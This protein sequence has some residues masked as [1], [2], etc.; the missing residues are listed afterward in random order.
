M[1]VFSTPL[2][3]GA[4]TQFFHWATAVLVLAAFVT[5]LG[6]SEQHVYSSALDSA[7]RIHETLGAAVFSLVL[8]RV[9]WRLFDATHVDSPMKPWM[10]QV[11]SVMHAMLYML[12]IA[13]PATG[14]MS[15]WLQGHPLTLL[16][17]GEIEP[18]LPRCHTIGDVA[19]LIH[20]TL[21]YVVLWASGFHAAAALFHHFFLRDRVL[22]SMLPGRSGAR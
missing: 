14:V 7:R 18:L 2:R 15:A 3:H 6:G 1:Q 19:A 8:V 21:G 20:T 22:L 16:G 12:L 11:S 9:L 5:G 4:F 13:L 17:L 10:K